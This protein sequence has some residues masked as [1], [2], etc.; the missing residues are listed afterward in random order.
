MKLNYS[1]LLRTLFSVLILISMPACSREARKERAIKAATELY[2]KGDFVAAEIELKNALKA[3]PGSKRALKQMGLIR[4][5]QGAHYEAAGI[6]AEA[7]RKLPVDTEV[8]L[9]LSKS[10]FSLGYAV[11][12]RKVLTGILEREPSHGE[13]L[14][15]LAETSVTQQWAEELEGRLAQVD[16]KTA[17]SQLAE[18]IAKLRRG[19]VVEGAALVDEVLES[20]PKIAR[21]HALKSSILVS[22]KE[23]D[24]AL[25]EMKQAAELGGVRSNESIGYARMLVASDRKDEAIAHLEKVTQAAPDYLPAWAALGQV[26]YAAKEDEKATAYFDKVLAK[27]PADPIT[28]V[29][30]TDIFLRGQQPDKAVEI[31]EKLTSA[32]PSRPPLDVLLAKTYLA[33]NEVPKAT[34]AL[35]R[36]L[37]VDKDHVEAG[38]LRAQVFLKEGKTS[39]GVQLLEA[40][41][42]LNPNNA[43]ARDL[44][45]SA[46]R[47]S[48]RNDDAV[49]LL[50]EKADA[51][52]SDPKSQLELGQMLAAMG[53]NDEARAMFQDTATSFG[54]N[55]EAVGNLAAMDLKMGKPE[56]AMRK[57]DGYLEKHPDSSDAMTLKAKLLVSN[58][59]LQEA[60]KLLR[61]AIELKPDNKNAYLLLLSMNQGEGALVIL[62]SYLKSFPDDSQASLSRGFLLQQLGRI[63][64]ARE[65]FQALIAKGQEL[66]AAHNNLAALESTS[67][68]DLKAAAEHARKAR[69]LD[70]SQPAIADTLGWIEWQLE[71]FPVALPLLQEAASKIGDSPEVQYHLGMAQNSMGLSSEAMVSL[72]KAAAAEADFPGKPEAIQQLALLKDSGNVSLEDLEK[73]VAANPKDVLS[74]TRLAEL[75]MQAGKNQEAFESY[76]KVID[77]SP[78]VAAPW[79][80]QARLLA[81]PLKNPTKALVLAAKARELAPTDP[82][83]LAALGYAKFLNG[84]HEEA[85]GLLKD[86]SRSL[87]DDSSV[88]RDQAL[89]AYSVGRIAEARGVMQRVAKMDAPEAA[90][91][92]TFLMLTSADAA[93]QT[94]I[95]AEVEK[96]LA[97]D[98]EN[99]PALMLQGELARAAGKNPEAN[100]LK[101]LELRPR[102][103]PARVRL[104]SLYL[105]DPAK[106]DEALK[107]ATTARISMVDDMDLTRIL[108]LVRFR[109]GEMRYAAQLLSEL[110]IKRPLTPD[111]LLV[112]G[113]AF[114]ETKESAKAKKSLNDALKA[115]LSD[116]DAAKAKTAL[117]SL[118]DAAEEE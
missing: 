78:S 112:Q 58:K 49:G 21:A 115:G 67:G 86:A 7:Q 40:I 83:A 94:G 77:A 76:Q 84:N 17:E 15:A 47:G 71:N 50:R 18:A 22:R 101:V 104:A 87:T 53:K 110:A 45:I 97:A 89:A 34:A 91:A 30:Q 85:Y 66:A 29:S 69:L 52:V 14:L 60:D 20:N 93:T 65:S 26:A 33:A 41:R 48:G 8:A 13:A 100:Y 23:M 109:K 68:K 113:L 61:K 42:K 19:L 79:I 90:E 72:G 108:A 2:Q 10:Y 43:E 54:D 36:V 1:S 102:F 80:G 75:Q 57:I 5:S 106:L 105:D 16:K 96:A 56:D 114:V 28:A 81:G 38:V 103:D 88:L 99:V 64:D 116:A 70:P 51:N 107:L 117:A 31:M 39:E 27:D 25:D 118:E 11:D 9:A 6:L 32:L 37:A 46:Y 74:L 59:N 24:A 92:E 44:L 98:P 82:R 95:A 12:S 73:R 35:D 111:E 63:D 3:D 4:S 62:E 55:L